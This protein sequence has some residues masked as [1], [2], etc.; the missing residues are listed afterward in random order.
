MEEYAKSLENYTDPSLSLFGNIL[1]NFLHL[2]R[3]TISSSKDFS[4]FSMS[5]QRLLGDQI[6]RYLK[7]DKTPST[8]LFNELHLSFIKGEANIQCFIKDQKFFFS[9]D[10]KRPE[11]IKFYDESGLFKF[12]EWYINQI[13]KEIEEK[14][15]LL[16]SRQDDSTAI[17][18]LL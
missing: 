15:Q 16:Q 4:Q 6:M 14:R 11:V 13:K 1:Y 8:K 3:V 5:E 18:D 2:S 17:L 10:D 7:V 12:C 9:I